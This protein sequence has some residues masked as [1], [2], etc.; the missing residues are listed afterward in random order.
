MK[1]KKSVKKEFVHPYRVGGWV[2]LK[3]Y[4]RVPGE[5][6]KKSKSGD[7]VR[8]CFLNGSL[9]KFYCSHHDLRN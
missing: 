5:W 9:I 3:A 4:S 8:T 2:R 1:I 7:F 6:V